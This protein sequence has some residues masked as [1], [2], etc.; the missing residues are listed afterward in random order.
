MP[1]EPTSQTPTPEPEMHWILALIARKWPV[2]KNF[3]I[4]IAC[5]TLGV[6]AMIFLYD[7]FIIAGKQEQIDL[8]NQ[9]LNDTKNYPEVVA[10]RD[11][12]RG[13]S[14]GL[15][16]GNSHL[17]AAL[18]Q[19]MGSNATMQLQLQNTESNEAILSD[20]I[21]MFREQIRIIAIDSPDI[22]RATAWGQYGY[23]ESRP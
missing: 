10:E 6:V 18:R 13:Q 1:T 14:N 3:F 8:L 23:D 5:V 15:V 11:W 16:I 9:K 7:K 21:S 19:E 4:H 17:V 2:V 12:L 22:D 20:D